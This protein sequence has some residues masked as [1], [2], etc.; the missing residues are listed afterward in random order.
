MFSNLKQQL[1]W[2]APITVLVIVILVFLSQIPQ[3]ISAEVGP[4]VIVKN[5]PAEI[6]VTAVV[7]P[8]WYSLPIIYA[9]LV[10]PGK[11][12]NTFTGKAAFLG[13]LRK[14]GKD[15][16]GNSVYTGRFSVNRGTAETEQVQL[17]TLWSKEAY[18][19]QEIYKNDVYPK[20]FTWPTLRLAVSTR[21]FTLPPDSGEAG[22]ATL[23]GIDSDHDGVRDDIQRE[24]FFQ[25][26][27]SERMR[28]G[29][30]QVLTTYGNQIY[31]VAT[32]TINQIQQAVFLAK[33]CR[34]SLLGIRFGGFNSNASKHLEE[35]EN[36]LSTIDVNSELRSN[37]G[38]QISNLIDYTIIYT[39]PK[40]PTNA[41]VFD[42]Q[43]LPD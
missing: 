34:Q 27:E 40:P 38:K 15:T 26:P 32:S 9:R 41:C 24:I 7:K 33:V 42:W 37:R 30:S 2:L 16:S 18:P 43:S 8:K 1:K 28:K 31:A 23:E 21:N 3:I 22:K 6:S 29:F 12:I 19:S 17:K 39:A 5:Q 14:T 4:E 11:T 20:A 36:W 10:K 13:F 25:Y 35:V